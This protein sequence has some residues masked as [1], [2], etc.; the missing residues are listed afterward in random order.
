MLLIVSEQVVLAKKQAMEKRVNGSSA[1]D[2]FILQSLHRHGQPMGSGGLHYALRE[3][4]ST[5]SAP[6]LG[7][8]L[9]DLEERGLL[10]KISV[11]GRILTP[12]G[13]KLLKKLEMER[14]RELSGERLLKLLKRTGRGDIVDQLAVR[15]LAEA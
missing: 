6:T 8:K 9:R 2:Y 13:Q 3:R 14:Q 5:P 1:L 4:G 15:R 11:E 12:A 7:R 10:A